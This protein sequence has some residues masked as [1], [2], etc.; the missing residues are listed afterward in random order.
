MDCSLVS[1]SVI[2]AVQTT[3]PRAAANYTMSQLKLD[4]NDPRSGRLITEDDLNKMGLDLQLMLNL[5]NSNRLKCPDAWAQGNTDAAFVCNNF[6]GVQRSHR[7]NDY[8]YGWVDFSAERGTYIY[9]PGEAYLM[10]QITKPVTDVCE[11]A[12]IPVTN[13]S[14]ESAMVTETYAE[15][16][17]QSAR[18]LDSWSTTLTFKAQFK[19][20]DQGFELEGSL[21]KGNESETTKAT[22]RNSSVSIQITA[23]PNS[24]SSLHVTRT[25]TKQ[26]VMYGLDLLVGSD[27]PGGSIGKA[28]QNQNTWDRWFKWEDIFPDHVKQT[29]KFMVQT[30]HIVTNVELRPNGSKQLQGTKQ[31]QASIVS[32]TR[33][34]AFPA[35]L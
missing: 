10:Q 31:A 14:S 4:T 13:T 6:V 23:P 27:N 20:F 19:M 1:V 11:I 35:K 33:P 15:E 2:E 16:T 30:T 32:A 22:T 24:N 9:T 28:T 7:S 17:T 18:I 26:T 21:Q 5:T 25:T 8:N 3:S 29:A 12:T 34:F